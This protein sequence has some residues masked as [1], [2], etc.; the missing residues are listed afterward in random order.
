MKL[1]SDRTCCALYSM[2]LEQETNLRGVD[3]STRASPSTR[4]QKTGCPRYGGRRDMAIFL[5]Q[6]GGG[7]LVP[8]L[9]TTFGS[10]PRLALHLCILVLSNPFQGVQR[11]VANGEKSSDKPSYHQILIGG[12][13]TRSQGKLLESPHENAKRAPRVA[14]RL[15]S[16]FV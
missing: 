10:S 13:A 11:H 1:W 3:C 12:S 14:T 2:P 4:K 5:R 16:A 9:P 8:R 7:L 6:D 15:F